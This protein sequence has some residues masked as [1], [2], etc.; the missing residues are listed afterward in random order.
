M[1]SKHTLRNFNLFVDGVGYAGSIDELNLP[2][3][4]IKTEEYRA[5]GM[6]APVEID[7]GMDKMECDYTVSRLDKTVL[8]TYG[9]K[10]GE[11]VPVTVRG[12]I[13]TESDG[14]EQPVVANLRGIVKEIDMG[15]WKAG[16][17]AKTKVMMALRYYKLTINKQD[18]Y[19]IDTANLV[20]KINGVDYMAQTRGNI[21]L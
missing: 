1:L 12:S 8:G 9:I 2:K 3:M 18:V 10:V 13:L 15:A 19:E 5:G 11:S 16:D 17:A 14:T 6:D 7:M 21:G 4:T 20:R